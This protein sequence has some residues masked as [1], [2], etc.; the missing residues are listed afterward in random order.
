MPKL[1]IRPL[2]RGLLFI[3]K[4]GFRVDQ[5]YPK[6]QIVWKTD[7]IIQNAKTQKRLKICQKLAI[8]P[9]TRDI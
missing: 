8:H 7:K 9:S 5:K 2:T 6:T 1:A 3:G 4:Q